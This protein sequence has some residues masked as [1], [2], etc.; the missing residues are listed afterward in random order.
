MGD[1]TINKKKDL[2][3]Y[4]EKYSKNLFLIDSYDNKCTYND[5]Y[6]SALK[7]IKYFD[8]KGVKTN[9][10][11]LIIKENSFDYLI[12]LYACLLGA[13]LEPYICH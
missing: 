2:N 5:F 3:R 1:K 9:S 7:L 13:F 6:L 11:I 4:F 8:C 10:K 12:I